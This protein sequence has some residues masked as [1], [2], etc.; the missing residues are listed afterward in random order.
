[1]TN[2]Q[3]NFNELKGKSI[4]EMTKKVSEELIDLA[5]KDIRF[6]IENLNI[7]NM[8]TTEI[9]ENL[10]NEMID[11]MSCMVDNG[12][13]IQN[14]ILDYLITKMN[15]YINI[16]QGIVNKNKYLIT[17]YGGTI[18]GVYADAKFALKHVFEEHE[19]TGEILQ[20]IE[21]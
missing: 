13:M 8:A 11:I 16:C 4:I 6:A 20:I 14:P 15:K 18:E 3:P 19:K 9:Y 12:K 7:K 10:I 17:S 2:T 21:L 1:M 5:E